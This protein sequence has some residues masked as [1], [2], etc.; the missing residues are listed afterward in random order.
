MI[1]PIRWCFE[2][3]SDDAIP[4][5]DCPAE[6]ARSVTFK[7]PSPHTLLGINVFGG[8]AT[9]I[10]ISEIEKDSLAAMQGSFR[11]GDRILQV[12]IWISD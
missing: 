8:N 2:P 3:F 6:E 5:E 11:I 1:S 7:R 9:G 12:N 10:F 4:H